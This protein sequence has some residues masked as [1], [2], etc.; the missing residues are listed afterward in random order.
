MKVIYNKIL[1]FK[2]FRAMV[3]FGVIFARSKNKPLPDTVINHER[4]HAAQAKDCGGWLWFY[5]RYFWFWI[6]YGFY[7]VKIPF[8]REA[9]Y[10][11]EYSKYLNHRKNKGWEDF[12]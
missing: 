1:P 3:L 2:G 5:L 8:E 12:L 11:Q 6:K 7:Y 10:Y 9:Y 4:I